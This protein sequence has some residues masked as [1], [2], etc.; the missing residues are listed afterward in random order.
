M[1]TKPYKTLHDILNNHFYGSIKYN[2]NSVKRLS[3]GEVFTVGDKIN[4][5]G[6]L[7]NCQ[8][9]PILEIYISKFNDGLFI[10]TEHYIGASINIISKT[11]Q[12]SFTTE[13]GV[14]IYEGNKLWFIDDD[15]W[16]MNE[17]ITKKGDT[18]KNRG[19]FPFSNKQLAEEYLLLNK[20]CLSYYDVKSYIENNNFYSATGLKYS[21]PL[22][23]KFKILQELVK[24]KFKS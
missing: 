11:K 24:S 9:E 1:E 2:I 19:M 14:E 22:Y 4:I 20:P 17:R 3:D 13:D 6:S 23:N 12:P 16:S 5:K 21:E 8:N 18:Y 10:N 7:N 15:D